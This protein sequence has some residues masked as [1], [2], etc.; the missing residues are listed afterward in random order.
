ML[1]NILLGFSTSLTPENLLWCLV[2]VVLGTVIGMLPGL[3]ATTGVAILLPLTL[4]MEPVTAL[5][6]LAGIYYGCQYGGTIAAVLI[7]TP[8]DANAVATVIDGYALARK[9]QAGKALAIAAIGSFCA[10]I[11]SLILLMLVAAPIA[12][13]AL[14]FGPPEMLAI[15][16]MG[17]LTIIS[18]SGDNLAKGLMMAG[19]GLFL[20]TVGMSSGFA[21]S[22]FTFG[23]VQLLGGIDFVVVMIGVFAIGEVLSQVNSGGVAPIRT[24]MRDMVIR[25]KDIKES[26]PSIAR[27]TGVGFTLG[28]LP[29][30]GSTLAA[31]VAYG[32]E[33]QVS[34]FRANFGKGA[35]QGVASAESANNAAANAN[36]IPTLAL[37]VPGGTTTAV[38]LGAFIMY[39]IQPGPLLFDT[40]PDLVWGLLTSFFIGNVI[41]LVLNVPLAPV[42]AQALRLPY[43][44]LYP[45][46]IFFSILGA[47]AVGNN[48]FALSVLFVSGVAGFFFKKYDYPT[49]P[50]IL[51]LVLGPMVE[52]A[53]VQTS[54]Y[55]N[56]D[57]SIIFR[58]PISVIILLATF[59]IMAIPAVL[60]R[61]L[62]KSNNTNDI[63]D[64]D[65][66]ESAESL[67]NKTLNAEEFSADSKTEI[68]TIKN[69]SSFNNVNV[70]YKE[71]E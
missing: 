59:L 43:S 66:A 26:L 29:G 60:K 42:F 9:G 32:F 58:Q 37:G 28:T 13:F 2:G 19:L 47:F 71:E 33:K 50:L 69:S 62:K 24:R 25:R 44:Y 10:A 7:A 23:S 3:G 57:L 8:G 65:K 39:G 21:K 15:M 45:L 11:V 1:E 56:G 5:I 35:I 54:S 6:M 20:S 48:V 12:N 64:V 36:F 30:A 34:R 46:I 51:G 61:V 16:I 17:L 40:Q 27:G 49:A 70:D 4:G 31:L 63:S 14:K 67:E 38:L 68:G 52:R 53:L 55:A 41:L 18:F 22:R